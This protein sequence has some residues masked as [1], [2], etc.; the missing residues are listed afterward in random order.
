MNRQRITN[1]QRANSSEMFFP[2]PGNPGE[3]LFQA[4]EPQPQLSAAPS[5]LSYHRPVKPDPDSAQQQRDGHEQEPQHRRAGP[6]ARSALMHLAVAGLDAKPAPVDLG[7]RGNL[8]TDSLNRVGQPMAAPFASS[9]RPIFGNDR[10][11]KAHRPVLGAVHGVGRPVRDLA[12]HQRPGPSRAILLAPHH[13]RDDE[14]VL[15]RLQMLDDLDGEELS[16]QQQTFHLDAQRLHA[17]SEPVQD[18]RQGV[19]RAHKGQRQGE[20]AAPLDHKGRGIGVK[21][22]RAVFRLRADH[23]RGVLLGLAVIGHQDQIAGDPPRLLPQ[24]LGQLLFQHPVGS[25]LHLLQ[26]QL[27]LQ[28]PAHGVPTGGGLTRFA[29][30][31]EAGLLGSGRQHHLQNLRFTVLP[32][33]HVQTQVVQQCLQD[34]PVDLLIVEIDCGLFV[35]HRDHLHLLF[36]AI[37]MFFSIYGKPVTRLARP[38]NA[39][40]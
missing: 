16:I 8:G 5:G 20:P 21:V 4:E 2:E 28:H 32:P 40:Y 37:P 7:N 15:P 1:L 17:R 11:L 10:H 27:G 23:L 3:Q 35:V 22:G 30:L 24:P 14:P 33:A 9:A 39:I 25:G 19:G 38:Q 13:H 29:D 36:G 6:G 12:C 18:R 26:P 31:L 34:Q